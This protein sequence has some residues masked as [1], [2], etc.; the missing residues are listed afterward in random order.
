MYAFLYVF[1]FFF[2]F[3]CLRGDSKGLNCLD[4]RLVF[5]LTVVSCYDRP[6]KGLAFNESYRR[7]K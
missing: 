5:S 6:C 3:V 4:I 1:G 7:Q 2:L